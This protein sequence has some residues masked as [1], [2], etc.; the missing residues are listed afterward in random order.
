MIAAQE[1]VPPTTSPVISAMVSELEWARNPP[2]GRSI[3][4]A[5]YDAWRRGWIFEAVRGRGYGEAWCEHFEIFDY[6]IYYS[7]TVSGADRLI[8]EWYVR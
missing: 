3:T 6:V 4:L 5:E 7:T 8:Q 1:S 2:R